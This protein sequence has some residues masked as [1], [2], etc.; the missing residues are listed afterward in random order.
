VVSDAEADP[1]FEFEALG[2]LARKCRSDLGVR[3]EIDVTPLRRPAAGGTSRWHCAGGAI[4]HDDV[5]PK[6]IPGLLVYLKASLTGDEPSDV[7][8]YAVRHPEFPHEPTLDQFFSESQFESYRA[9]G[10]HV[11]HEVFLDPVGETMRELGQ[12]DALTDKEHKRV[13]N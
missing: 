9:L 10:Y 7:Q 11:A 6:A 13:V 4:R 1:E 12:T 8:N 3:V 5:D 2:V